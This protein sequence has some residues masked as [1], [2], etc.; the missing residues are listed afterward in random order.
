MGSTLDFFSDPKIQGLLA[1][2]TI[3]QLLIAGIKNL[4]STI[5]AIRSS[6]NGIQNATKKPLSNIQLAVGVLKERLSAVTLLRIL[7]YFV[8]GWFYYSIPWILLTVAFKWQFQNALIMIVSLNFV[9]L[10]ASVL[11]GGFVT[12]PRENIGYFLGGGISLGALAVY[13]TY[14]NPSMV[15]TTSRQA[16]FLIC[17]I[18]GG[19]F[20]LFAGTLTAFTVNLF[21]KT[22]R[23][24]PVKE[25]E[26]V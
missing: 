1:L 2:I 22:T 12:K 13:L 11:L 24:E 8:V 17:M 19:M 9:F 25:A 16:W 6:W 10:S 3:I 26:V 23:S 7:G 20:G 5:R 14:A 21:K 4:P 15:E 18:I